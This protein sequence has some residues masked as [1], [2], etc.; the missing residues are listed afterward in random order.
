[1]ALTATSCVALGAEPAS[2]GTVLR[3]GGYFSESHPVRAG[4]VEPFLEILRAEGPGV[5]LDVRY[6]GGGQLADLTT[7]PEAMRNG[8]VQLGPIAPSNVETEFQMSTV[9]DLPGLVT[10][11][12]TG[13]DA[14][15][16]LVEPGGILFEKE[17]QPGGIRPLWIAMLQ[18]FEAL[19][20]GTPVHTPDDLRGLA[21]RSPGGAGDRVVRRAGAAGVS[22]PLNE[23]YQGVLQGTVEGTLASP[24]SIAAYKLWEVLGY[25][26]ENAHLGAAAITYNIAE[27][28]WQELN[29]GQ[30]AV[31]QKAA[32]AA[33]ASVCQAVNKSISDN[34][35][36][37]RDA[38]VVFHTVTEADRAAWEGLAVPVRQE[39]VT[40]LESSG[41]PAAGEVLAEYVAALEEVRR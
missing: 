14:L 17:F 7:M 5:G 23:V 13:A 26:T 41:H 18:G 36:K 33:Q 40:D 11:S 12:C 2:R 38:G 39:W 3:V 34:K 28:T 21:L 37:M 30:R 10:E 29:D 9:A 19:T 15:L 1:M 31:V 35:Q 6:Y 25:S 24:T 8:L 22:I 16:N 4:G 20:S 32:A 27:D